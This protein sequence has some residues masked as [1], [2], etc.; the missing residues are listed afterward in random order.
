MK[1]LFGCEIRTDIVVGRSGKTLAERSGWHDSNVV[2]Q[3]GS[4]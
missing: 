2:A 4:S 1:K 3:Q